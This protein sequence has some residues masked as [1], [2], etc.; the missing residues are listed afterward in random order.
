MKGLVISCCLVPALFMGT[1]VMGQDL[2]KLRMPAAQEE[3]VDEL[4][5]TQD[6]WFYLQELKRYDDPHVMLRRVAEKKGEQRRQRLAAMK[7]F[8]FSPSRPTAN[9]IPSMGVHSP[10]WIGGGPDPYQWIGNAYVAT[11]VRVETNS[12]KQR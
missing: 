12:D 1:A 3:V 2:D 11:T 9:P 6:M 5:P 4:A 8:G 10:M 7:W